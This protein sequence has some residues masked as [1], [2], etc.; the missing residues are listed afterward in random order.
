MTGLALVSSVTDAPGFEIPSKPAARVND[1]AGLLDAGG[2]QAVEALLAGF[3]KESSTQVAVAIVPELGGAAIEDVAVRVF[4]SWG[5]GQKGDNNGVLLLVAVADRRARIEVG[6]GLEDRLTDALS[7]RILEDRLFPSFRSGAYA[8]GVLSTCQG[9]VDATRGAYVGRPARRRGR[10]PV[11]AGLLLAAVVVA[12]VFA[13]TQGGR[14]ISRRG[15]RR[16]YRSGP[17][18]WG[19]GLG[20]GSGGGFGGGGGG[21]GGF[22]GG[23]G[24]SGGGGASGSW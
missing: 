1:Y 18:W 9:I 19:G 14:G 5:L 22:S 20:G 12:I 15:R 21:F 13:A 2:A 3:E 4:E 10:L 7:R 16:F 17:A 11:V 23:G 8:Q 6:Y 24:L